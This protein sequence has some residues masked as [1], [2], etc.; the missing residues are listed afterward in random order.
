MRSYSGSAQGCSGLLRAYSGILRCAYIYL[1]LLI[2]AHQNYQ[3][4]ARLSKRLSLAEAR[5]PNL[6]LSL[7]EPR[8]I[9]C[10][11]LLIK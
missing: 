2:P 3:L 10:V 4:L 5:D 6:V 9:L 1:D 11:S 7:L 8:D